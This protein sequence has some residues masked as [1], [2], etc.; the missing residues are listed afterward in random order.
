MSLVT[1]LSAIGLNSQEEKIFRAL[2]Q[3]GPSLAAQLAS[4]ME[5]PRNTV[6]G[7]LD[8]LVGKGI[9]TRAKE[10]NRF[11]Y[12]VDNPEAIRNAIERRRD[13]YVAEVEGQLNLLKQSEGELR[14]KEQRTKRPRV[15]V[16]SGLKGLKQLYEDTLTA[17][18]GIRSWASF[19]ANDAHLPAYFQ[20]YYKR[21][22]GKKIRMVSIHPDTPLAREGIKRNRKE[23]RTSYL[24]STELFNIIPE[25]QVYEDKVN[26]TSWQERVGVLIESKEIASAVRAIFDLSRH[27]LERKKR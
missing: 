24:V 7:I 26:I 12:S 19:D 20:S 4:L 11:I 8:Q 2:L 15:K 5:L 9:V 23:L 17:E 25:I 27:L 18:S 10:K 1:F 14:Q 22:A 13:A 21:R 3:T 6:R 16:F